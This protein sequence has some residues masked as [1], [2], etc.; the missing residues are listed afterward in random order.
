MALLHTFATSCQRMR[1]IRE[2]RDN[3]IRQFV[4]TNWYQSWEPPFGEGRHK[5][6]TEMIQSQTI[7]LFRVMRASEKD[8]ISTQPHSEY[9]SKSPSVVPI[10]KIK[11]KGNTRFYRLPFLRLPPSM[12]APASLTSLWSVPDSSSSWI[13]LVVETL[14]G[15]PCTSRIGNEEDPVRRWRTGSSTSTSTRSLMSIA[16]GGRR[17]LK[18][19]TRERS[20]RVTAE[21]F[22]HASVSLFFGD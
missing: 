10:K 20:S 7:G 5:L 1:L 4:S 8:E 15:V 14:I 9:V 17:R 19:S 16:M 2:S 22:S 11:G 18:E 21:G 6:R 3:K 12:M 13:R